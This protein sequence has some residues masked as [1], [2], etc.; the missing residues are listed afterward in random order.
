MDPMGGWENWTISGVYIIFWGGAHAALFIGG[1]GL[2]C[3]AS[4][5]GCI[6]AVEGALGIG[7]AVSVDGDPT[8][9]IR[10]LGQAGEISWGF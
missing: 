8:N 10:A 9:E 3:A 6:A 2:L 5:P 1:G 7:G 4:G